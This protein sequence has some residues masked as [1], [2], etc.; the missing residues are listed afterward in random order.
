MF[1]VFA[2]TTTNLHSEYFLDIYFAAA[3]AAFL[4]KNSGVN[5]PTVSKGS[6][7]RD[8]PLRGVSAPLK[9]SSGLPVLALPL[10]FGCVVH[11]SRAATL[12]TRQHF[13][14]RIL[15]AGYRKTAA[16]QYSVEA[17]NKTQ[18]EICTVR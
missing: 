14:D 13:S 6:H 15:V 17:L 12:P 2:R 5:I 11:S 18:S 7:T 16:K 10:G 9:A 3:A 4:T 1:L 8:P